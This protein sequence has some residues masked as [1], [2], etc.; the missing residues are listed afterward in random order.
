MLE[1]L[2]IFERV[3]TC[4]KEYIHKYVNER[5]IYMGNVLKISYDLFL[6]NQI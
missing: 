5:W 1:N 2:V 4:L 3:S 6:I